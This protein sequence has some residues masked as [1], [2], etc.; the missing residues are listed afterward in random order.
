MI[1]AAANL[2]R[3]M[4]R[5]A[6]TFETETGIPAVVS[7]GSTS[8]L[9]Q[10]IE[11][12]APFDVFLSADTAHVDRLVEAGRAER[13]SRRVY[14]RGRLA[15]WTSRGSSV[16]LS[17]PQAL[18]DP[19]VRY[20]AVANPQFAPYGVA[21]EAVLERL[22]YRERLADRIVFAQS[23][24]MAQQY[25]DSGNADVAV[26]ALSLAIGSG[27]TWLELD[28]SLHRPIEQGLVVLSGAPYR[29]AAERFAAFLTGPNG[30]AILNE[31]GYESAD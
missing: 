14:A 2:N 21:A 20:I 19:H 28:E 31:F 26:T 23:I 4:P 15:L 18:I 16:E 12:G 5:L 29:A 7:F 1:A 13:A 11:N 27:G 30:Q 25:A 22:G 3:V 10:Q 17:G 6:A 9:T 24:S 8:G